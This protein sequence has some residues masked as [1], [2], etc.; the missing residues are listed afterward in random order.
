MNN[1]NF[2]KQLLLFNKKLQIFRTLLPY[3]IIQY[4]MPANSQAN[5]INGSKIGPKMSR[6]CQ[7]KVVKL[8]KRQHQNSPIQYANSFS[9]S[10]CQIISCLLG[11]SRANSDF[12]CEQTHTQKEQK[13]AAHAIAV[14]VCVCVS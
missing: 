2:Q 6:Q 9:S 8:L 14:C 12:F 7:F 13:S 3:F 11:F 10:N 4:K 1:I 5:S